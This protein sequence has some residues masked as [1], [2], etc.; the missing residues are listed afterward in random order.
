[1]ACQEDD[2]ESDVELE[3]EEAEYDSMLIEN[4]G[5]VIPAVATVVGG[6]NFVPYFQEFLPDLLKKLV[7]L[8]YFI[9]SLK[10]IPFFPNNLNM[11]L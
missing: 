1:M 6:S 5:D 4:A 10:K 8:Y 9:I 7:R 11:D 3:D 2:N